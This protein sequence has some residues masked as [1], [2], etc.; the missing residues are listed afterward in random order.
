MTLN[1]VSLAQQPD[2]LPGALS[3]VEALGQRHAYVCKNIDGDT[4]D[5]L[6]HD[7]READHFLE[8]PS[9]TNQEK[10]DAAEQRAQASQKVL[11]ILKACPGVQ[12][13]RMTE[14]PDT[15][16]PLPPLS[17]PG[18]VAAILFR[19]EQGEG[20]TRCLARTFDLSVDAGTRFSVDIEHGG[21][22]WVLA[23]LE[24]IPQGRT[25]LQFKFIGYGDERKYL[26][27]ETMTL[28]HGIL[29]IRVLSDDSGDPAPAMMRLAWKTDGTEIRPANAEDFGVLF[30]K[31][32]NASGL[33]DANIPGMVTICAGCCVLLLLD[34]KK[35]FAADLP[36]RPFPQHVSYMTGA[37]H[38]SHRS[39]AQQ[40]DDLRAAYDRWKAN[41][42]AKTSEGHYRVKNGPGATAPTVSEGQGYGMVIVALM[43]GYDTEAQVI[44]D[45]LWGFFDAHR[46]PAD[47]RLMAWRVDPQ[48]P[49]KGD[50][51]SAF[52]GD[53]DIAYGLLLA[54]CQ[55]GSTRG[56]GI[57]YL[58]EANRVLSGILAR[59]VGPVSRLPMLGNWFS[60]DGTPFNQYTPRTS[61]FMPAHFRVF[62]HAT[63]NPVWERVIAACQNVVT[64]FQE[65][66]SSETG[67]LPDFVVVESSGTVRPA[68]PRFLETE[69]DGCY[70]FNAGR[71]PWRLGTDALLSGDS[72]SAAQVKKMAA[73][74][75]EET[76]GNPHNIKPGYDLDGSPIASRKYFSSFFAAPFGV[77]AMV[78]GQQEWLNAIYDAVRSE[79]QGYYADTVTLLCLVVMTGNYWA[80]AT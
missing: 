20:P 47:S 4:L 11:E 59:E 52:D 62:G 19:V 29:G 15:L 25:S 78:A 57:N 6:R 30:D 79:E 24:R 42:L 14:E 12:V 31:Q 32:G 77:A 18:D 65:N 22:T 80:P 17:V 64:A 13:I 76:S 21:T 26:P 28:P 36:K 51:N 16:D 39:Q 45:G 53:A 3:M 37:V 44:F 61:D 38:P 9:A 8:E 2:P 5:D 33:R 7:L 67:L 73:W 35:A 49:D 48:Q 58:A 23:A 69:W 56:N 40:D 34:G 70:N 63:A 27:F 10:E 41:Y 68:P 55:W 75:L 74:V 50:G 54:D 43:A 1:Y 60:P 72:I 66:G 46:S 71:L